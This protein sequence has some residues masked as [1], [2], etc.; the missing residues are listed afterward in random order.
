MDERYGYSEDSLVEQPAIALLAQL[1]WETQNCYDEFNSGVSP[2]GRESKGDVVLISRL[3]P[4]LR[5]VESWPAIGSN[6]FS[7][8]GTHPRS[9]SAISGG[10]QSGYLPVTEKRYQRYLSGWKK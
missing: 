8:R 9:Q 4:I 3:R 2:L 7:Y 6:I 1:G 10:C 5:E